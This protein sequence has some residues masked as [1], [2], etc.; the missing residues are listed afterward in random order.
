MCFLHI[1]SN[2]LKNRDVTGWYTWLPKKKKKDAGGICTMAVLDSPILPE[3]INTVHL[4]FVP[5]TPPNTHLKPIHKNTQSSLC[6]SL[7]STHTR[8]TGVGCTLKM[9]P[10]VHVILKTLMRRLLS[11][12]SQ[13]FEES[14][15]SLR[16]LTLP[17]RSHW[18]GSEAE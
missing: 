4:Y 5:P 8:K 15:V 17:P 11:A 7:P 10:G 9:Q 6:A 18:F 1:H 16:V 13:V 3:Q 14:G 12:K 2:V